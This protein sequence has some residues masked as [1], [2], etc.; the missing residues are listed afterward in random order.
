MEELIA[1][2]QL[3][4]PWLPSSLVTIF[5]E[6]W[7]ETGD[8][9]LALQRTRTTDL[10]DTIFPG[11]R[12][13][14]G[15]F[16]MNEAEYLA[17]QDAYRQVLLD[18]NINP[19]VIEHRFASLIEGDVNPG[20]FAERVNAIASRLEG[21]IE[22]NRAI[23]AEQF[24]VDPTNEAILLA[25]LD[26]EIGQ[27]ILEKSIS[28]VDI[29]A[30]ASLRGFSP[31]RE[32]VDRLYRF[33]VNQAAAREVFGAAE[34]DLPFLRNLA[35]RHYDPEDN[36]TLGDFLEANV[37]GDADT[38]QRVRLLLSQEQALFTGNNVVATSGAGVT[39]LT[40]QPQT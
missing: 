12:R 33:G 13:E 29:S 39:G 21:N 27:N 9:A 23:F 20:E 10:Y 4:Y 19:A 26:P 11:I 40:L 18:W 17:I 6:F 31:S 2:A 24:G 35:R 30:E 28:L 16:R 3:L 36:F 8:P 5:A 38:R 7:V 32:T 14:D 37:F 15:S 22:Q 1:Q 34:Q 25:A